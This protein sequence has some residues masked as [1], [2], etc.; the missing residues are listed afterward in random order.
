WQSSPA[1]EDDWTDL[2]VSSYTLNL[3]DGVTEATDFRYYVACEEQENTSDIISVSLKPANQCY[4]I[5]EGSNANYYI[6]NF[7]TSGGVDNI[8]N[9]DSG[10]ENNGYN[11]YTAEHSAS[12][13]RTEPINFQAD[14][15]SG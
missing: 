5:P 9:L 4:C 6:N 3:S 8:E 14:F 7:T 2:N 11:D 13:V 10:A 1:G 12:Q 15:A